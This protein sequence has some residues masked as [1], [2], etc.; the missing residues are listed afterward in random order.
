VPGGKEEM[1]LLMA[2][3]NCPCLIPESYEIGQRSG[4]LACVSKS[5]QHNVS[6]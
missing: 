4:S 2:I 1:A 6:Q 3:L 5:S